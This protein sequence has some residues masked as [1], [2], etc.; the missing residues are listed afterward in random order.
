MGLFTAGDVITLLVMLAVVFMFRQLDRGNRSLDKVK[1]YGDRVM[2]TLSTFVDGKSSEIK[3]LAI[4]VQVSV[5]QG[6]ELLRTVRGVQEELT[7]RTRDLEDR[8]AEIDAIRSR[9]DGYDSA[10][11]ELVNMS[12]RVDEN[13]RRLRGEGERLHRVDEQRAA[14]QERLAG[15]DAAVASLEERLQRI[16]TTAQE[17]LAD[18][19]T[20]VEQGFLADLQRRSDDLE[21]R[22]VSWQAETDRRFGTM[23]AEGAERTA[24]AED[25]LIRELRERID[26]LRR[27]SSTEIESV[28]GIV[29]G[30]EA[31]VAER[32]AA[33]DAELT[34]IAA[35][36]TV[37]TDQTSLLE[38][39]DRMHEHLE[40]LG[41][42]MAAVQRQKQEVAEIELAL[43]R[44][45]KL[46]EEVSAKLARFAVDRRRIESMERDF[47]R[48]LAVSEEVD[49]KHAAVEA[50]R[51]ALEEVQVRLREL[52]E[53]S[54]AVDARYQQL[55]HKHE[56]AE[57]TSSGVDR[58]F[59]LL[60]HLDEQVVALR[61]DV[62][63]LAAG[64]AELQGRVDALAVNKES[65][66]A[67][68]RSIDGVEG[69]LS[70]LESRTQRLMTARDWLARAETRLEQIGQDARASVRELESSVKAQ[71]EGDG[72]APEPRPAINNREAVSKLAAQG[73][74]IP[75]IARATKLSRGE[76]ELILEV[77]PAGDALPKR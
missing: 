30:F 72:G 60:N 49:L 22:Q 14:L 9:I 6:K 55:A 42:R 70:D 36:L 35:R 12:E 58:N 61:P 28:T 59:E 18:K 65:A 27:R 31:D 25:G 4:E 57:A 74:S 50:G 37:F 20:G 38:R 8:S 44:T 11:A 47:Q 53:L 67:V 34:E 71:S 77:E 63:N 52:G 17:A 29:D 13:L 1:R 19:L 10:L 16:E 69:L 2:Q 54:E 48:L 41:E 66:D 68:I 45:K 32:F 21:A 15:F 56:T 40:R 26:E 46:G 5:K 43:D 64:L 76:V 23:Q 33:M 39:A 3:D 62:L 7:A 73:W 24:A 51:D 75:E